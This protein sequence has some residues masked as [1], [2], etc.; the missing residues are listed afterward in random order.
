[1][2]VWGGVGGGGVL[3]VFSF[4]HWPFSYL[5]YIGGIEGELGRENRRGGVLSSYVVSSHVGVLFSKFIWIII[6]GG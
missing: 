3:F 5:Y 6:S 2:T 1:M 4:R